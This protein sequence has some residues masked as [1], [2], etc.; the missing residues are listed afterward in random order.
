M[1]SFLSSLACTLLLVAA[2]KHVQ[3]QEP[4]ERG[5]VPKSDFLLVRTDCLGQV[6]WSRTYSF[7]HSNSCD[8]AIATRSGGF[9]LVGWADS[10]VIGGK[11]GFWM[12][13]TDG[14]GVPLWDRCYA[15]DTDVKR[16][17]YAFCS[18]LMQLA[19]GRF[20]VA[21]PKSSAC[22]RQGMNCGFGP[23]MRVSA[24]LQFPVP[25]A[26]SSLPDLHPGLRDCLRRVDGF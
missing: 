21:V 24:G 5:P 6:L 1:R 19:D 18:S 13:V 17:T 22:Q 26:A 15:P 25:M 23:T 9:A 3:A 4:M 2:V 7:G 16:I 20:L 10:C 14:Q 8:A 11:R 12:V